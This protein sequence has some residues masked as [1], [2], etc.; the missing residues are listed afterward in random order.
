[1]FTSSYKQGRTIEKRK[2]K[3]PV[4]TFKEKGKE[5]DNRTILAVHKKMIIKRG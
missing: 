1:M 5:G 4:G 2:R 3:E